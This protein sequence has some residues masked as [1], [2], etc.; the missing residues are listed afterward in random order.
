MV[1]GLVG[2]SF[3]DA[4]VFCGGLCMGNAALRGSLQGHAMGGM[5]LSGKSVLFGRT[6]LWLYVVPV[7]VPRVY[8]VFFTVCIG[9]VLTVYVYSDSLL[10]SYPRHGW[11]DTRG[12]LRMA[13]F[14]DSFAIC[15]T[16]E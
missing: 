6:V 16:I 2:I 12:I 10:A 14:C 7:S 8:A 11:R 15:Y 3:M 13:A 9:A 4:V 1:A 5:V